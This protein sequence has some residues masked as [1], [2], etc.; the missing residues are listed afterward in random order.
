[1]A[2]K[3]RYI[4]QQKQPLSNEAWELIVKCFLFSGFVIYL[5]F[6]LNEK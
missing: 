1:M 3:R 6:K 2:K 4:E 5:I